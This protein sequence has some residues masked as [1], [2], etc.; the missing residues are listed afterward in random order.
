[1]KVLIVDDKG[2]MRHVIREIMRSA[3]NDPE[4]FGVELELVDEPDDTEK[5]LNVIFQLDGKVPMFPI[6]NFDHYYDREELPYSYKQ[7]RVR[8]KPTKGHRNYKIKHG[9]IWL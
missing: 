9:K 4:L 3:Q 1:M 6:L 7:E 8:M 5:N 2:Y